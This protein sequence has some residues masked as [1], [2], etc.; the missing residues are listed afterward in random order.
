MNIFVAR[1]SDSGSSWKLNTNHGSA[2]SEGH[3]RIV[4]LGQFYTPLCFLSSVTPALRQLCSS[5]RLHRITYDVK[6]FMFYFRNT[7]IVFVRLYSV[8]C[9]TQSLIISYIPFDALLGNRHTLTHHNCLP[10]SGS[11]FCLCA[12]ENFIFGT[13]RLPWVVSDSKS[14][15]CS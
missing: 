5:L 2:R 8:C 15:F 10:E 1:S 3:I 11:T 9:A 13:I 7:R 4:V 14:N 12:P 6:C